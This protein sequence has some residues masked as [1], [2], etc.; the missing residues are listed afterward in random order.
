MISE[1][2][3]RQKSEIRRNLNG[4]ATSNQRVSDLVYVNKHS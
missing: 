3:R 4:G 1:K 2:I